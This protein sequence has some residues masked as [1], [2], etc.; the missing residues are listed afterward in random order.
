MA[1]AAASLVREGIETSKITPELLAGHVYAPDIPPVDLVIRTSGEHRTSGFMLWRAAYAELYFTEK[2]W[3]DFTPAD[4][5][6]AIDD[7]G[8]RIRRFGR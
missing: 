2:S 8:Q 4:L 3:P 5:E 6:A 7:Y 1:D